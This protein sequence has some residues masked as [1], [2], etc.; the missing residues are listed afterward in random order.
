[1]DD[2]SII[3]LTYNYTDIRLHVVG[4]ALSVYR[5]PQSHQRAPSSLCT[6][7]SFCRLNSSYFGYSVLSVRLRSSTFAEGSWTFNQS[8]TNKLIGLQKEVSIIKLD[9][10]K[11]QDLLTD[12]TINSN[13]LTPLVNKQA[14]NR[15][16]LK[17]PVKTLDELNLIENDDEKIG[18]LAQ[19]L[20]RDAKSFDVKRSIYMTMKIIM[21]NRVAGY[22][23]MEGRRGDKT[24]FVK[25][26]IF[27]IVADFFPHYS[28]SVKLWVTQSF[29]GT[30]SVS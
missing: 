18:T 21:Q 6:P 8:V 12:L 25:Y 24:A 28:I 20:L 16:R 5:S 2:T 13:R 29:T 17:L 14:I 27:T 3:N 22:L 10:I 15:G 23:N 26:K 7:L 9:V 30:T 1:M 11:N 19:I 4:I